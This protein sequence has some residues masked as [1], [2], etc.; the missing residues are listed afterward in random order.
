M[1]ITVI[2]IIIIII[3]NIHTTF[4]ICNMGININ[5]IKIPQKIIEIIK[6]TLKDH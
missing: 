3:K 6:K 4:N 1:I 2:V 5:I